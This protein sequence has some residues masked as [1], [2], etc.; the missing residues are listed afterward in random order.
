MK[1]IVKPAG[2]VAV[3]GNTISVVTT[4]GQTTDKKAI[5]TTAESNG[6]VLVSIKLVGT[7]SNDGE[8]GLSL[9]AGQAVNISLQL[10]SAADGTGDNV[11]TAFTTSYTP[12]QTYT[13]TIDGTDG[14]NVLEFYLPGNP[15]ATQITTTK[16]LVANTTVYVKARSGLSTAGYRLKTEALTQVGTSEYYSFTLTEDVKATAATNDLLVQQFTLTVAD[17]DKVE[18]SLSKTT[19][20]AIGTGTPKYDKDTTIYVKLKSDATGVHI[21]TEG[22]TDETG[23]IY[24]FKLTA[25]KAAA[26]LSESD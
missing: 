20:S 12:K 6:T 26:G 22:L 7:E 13:V 1:V 21:V 14:N 24:S 25:N 2:G 16:A 17:S 11:G 19:W 10:K 9:T 3:A 8:L 15:N 18:C 5:G 4:V 23:G